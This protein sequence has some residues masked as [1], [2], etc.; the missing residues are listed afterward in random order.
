[1]KCSKCGKEFD[2]EF[3]PECGMAAASQETPS[4]VPLQAVQEKQTFQTGKL[5]I[6]IVSIVLSFW[7]IIQ[8]CAAGFV[9]VVDE[10][11]SAS[12]TMGMILSACWFVGGIVG[13]AARKSISGTFV[14]GGFFALGALFGFADI[15]VFADLAIWAIISTAFA[16]VFIF[17][18]VLDRKKKKDAAIS[19]EIKSVARRKKETMLA[20]IIAVLS[21][22]AIVMIFLSSQDKND[23]SPNINIAVV[24]N[25]YLGEF[26]D[27]TVQEMFNSYYQD[28]LSCK[29]EWD[30]G[31]NDDGQQIV[32][33]KYL[34]EDTGDTTIQFTMLDDQVFKVSAFV[35]PIMTIEK[36]SDLPARLNYFYLM[37]Y[38]VKHEADIGDAEKEKAFVERM[39]QIAGSAVLYGAAANYDGDRSALC[40]L[41][42]EDE[43]DVTVPWLLDSYGYFDM[44]YYTSADAV[45][46][47]PT[48]DASDDYIFPSDRQYITDA[49]M[50]DWDK[51]TASLARNEIYARHGYVFQTQDIQNYF[52]AKSWYFPDATY[53][54]SGLSDVEKANID[55]I[56]AYEQKQGWRNSTVSPEALAQQ[57]VTDYIS[58]QGSYCAGI[59]YV[60]PYAEGQYL[61]C[62]KEGEYEF[63]MLY[64]VEITDASASVIG[65]LDGGVFVPF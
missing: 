59:D 28:A 48:D 4:Q 6:G 64:V 53:D 23:T 12:G 22:I 17:G 65:Y 16:T 21:F 18:G 40:T 31:E 7:I 34:N 35:D 54:G 8:S 58:G 11:G 2:G 51:A 60:E 56:A 46:E 20:V 27:M 52:A 55:T 3:C 41:F 25:G 26:T 47:T 57:A 33:V 45:Q 13:I 10:T 15:G 24:Q 62:A 61:V 37:A 29:A 36:A 44:G 9:N 14:A 43:M 32:Q 19:V 42:E 63:E 50:V 39:D 1:M 30:G 49:D 5:V 38:S